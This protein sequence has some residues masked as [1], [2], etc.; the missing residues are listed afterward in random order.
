MLLSVFLLLLAQNVAPAPS[1]A[2]VD[3]NAAIQLAQE[4]R[5]GEALA[6]L[7]KIAAADPNNH[8]T[9][10]W[11]ANVHARMGHPDLAEAVYR[12]IVLEDAQNV[13][14]LVGLGTVL[15]QQDR[16][17]EGLDVLK[18]AEQLSPENPKV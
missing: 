2:A 1:T 8:L 9:R 3:L 15:L 18:R 6:A 13:D 5:N 14:A 11:I 16:V 17:S 12:S 10:L 7:Q 4:G